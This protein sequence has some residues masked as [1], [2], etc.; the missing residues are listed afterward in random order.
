MR[1]DGLLCWKCRKAVPYSVVHRRKVRTI[2]GKDYEYQEKYG[3][4]DICGEEIAV[5]G[6]I[7][8]NEKL[9]DSIYRADND[10]IT[11]DE[12]KKILEKY[13]IDKRPLSHVLGMGEHTISRYVD[14][15]M[16]S[17]R[18][19][20]FLRRMLAY[21]GLMRDMLEKNKES[22][23]ESAYK[24]TDEAI[25]KI[26][27]LCK[28]ESKIESI[29][30][31]IIHKGYEVTNL[32]LQ[33]LLY[34]VKAFSYIMLGK[35]VIDEE[36]EAWAYG[37]V[38]P[39][40]YEKYRGFGSSVIEDYDKSIDYKKLLSDEEIKVVDYIVNCLGIFNGK[41]LMNMTHKERPW[42]EARMGI[43][44]FAPSSNVIS[45]K[46]IQ[47]YF[48]EANHRYDLLVPDGVEHYVHD[49]GVLQ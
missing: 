33:K 25:S 36:C 14:G 26:E 10:L 24:R 17:K 12:I 44:E 9:L 4:C 28:S 6:L 29:A 27:I 22:I 30:L 48:E 15:A 18:Y 13:D 39:D 31:Y 35:S 47:D 8:E 43:P 20:D 41:V 3:V 16:P 38:F 5:P 21:H 45:E 32:S 40:I 42:L 11:I 46:V 23:S 49:L 37:P 1:K 19:S 2:G 34:Y 7:D